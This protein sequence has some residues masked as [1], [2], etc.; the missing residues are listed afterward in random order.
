MRFITDIFGDSLPL[1][2]L[3]FVVVA[4]F[5][6][7]L[8]TR[9]PAGP[10]HIGNGSRRYRPGG[11]NGRLHILDLEELDGVARSTLQLA[12]V[13]QASFEK[14]KLLSWNE[15]RAFQ[16]VERHFASLEPRHRVF[17]QV[18]LGEILRS[19]DEAA[20]RSINSK[21]VDILVVDSGGWPVLAI[22]YQGKG[23]HQ[24]TAAAR[25]AVKKEALRRA[26]VGYLEIYADDT[27]AQIFARIA[28]AMERCVPPVQRGPSEF[29][30]SPAIEP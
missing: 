27:E 10:P 20:F 30:L 15:Y 2:A 24:G 7:Y 1:A 18:N 17:A 9:T 5:V 8:F 11:S 26:G 23:H 3:A 19:N 29:P 14:Q 13:M 25:D 21:R 6:G 16:A 4:A 28:D 12:A 22:E